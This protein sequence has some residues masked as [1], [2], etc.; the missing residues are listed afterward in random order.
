MLTSADSLVVLS[1]DVST[2]GRRRRREHRGSRA[3][4]GFA[5]C[6]SA[7]F[8]LRHPHVSAA[9]PA[10]RACVAARVSQAGRP[11]AKGQGRGRLAG[12]QPEHG[13]Q[14]L[15]RAGGEGPGGRA[16][17]GRARSSRRR[18]ARSHCP[19]WPSFAAPC[20]AGWRPQTTAGLDADGIAALFASVL[21]DF[22]SAV[23]ARHGA[24]KRRAWH[25]RRRS[26]RPR[27]A[28]RQHMGAARVHARDSR[29]SR[30]CAGRP[31]R[32]RQDHAAEP[33][34]RAGGADRRR[35]HGARRPARRVARPRWTASR[36]LPRTRRCTR[37]CRSPTCCT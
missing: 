12:D 35:R 25:E 34:R 22:V 6:V 5:D 33:G 9:R 16:D 13:A 36:S 15:P 10:G 8:H 2:R 4:S 19:S 27:Q 11:A 17:R 28:L 31:E 32:R 20:S 7:R 21:R 26:Q 29:R 14:G 3:Q 37:T 18:S 1:Y 23:A 30:G 24:A